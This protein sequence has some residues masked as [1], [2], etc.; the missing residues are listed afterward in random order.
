MSQD[1]NIGTS[2]RRSI[3]V[4]QARTVDFMGEDCRVYATPSLV[5]DIE[6]ICRDLIVEHVPAGQDSV[7]TVVSIAHTSPTLL[8]MEAT[9]T[10][11]VTKIDGRRVVFDISAADSIDSIC[12]GRHERFIVDVNMTREKLRRKTAALTES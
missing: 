7:G 5:R 3:K 4:D 11:T 1:L 8:G 12:K 6:D 2:T 9:I 10:V